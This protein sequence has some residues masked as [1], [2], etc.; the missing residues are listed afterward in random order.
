MNDEKI[1]NKLWFKL[2]VE[3]FFN[4]YIYLGEKPDNNLDDLV[5]NHQPV[6]SDRPNGVN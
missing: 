4:D 2:C 5:E 1:E 3:E 6:M